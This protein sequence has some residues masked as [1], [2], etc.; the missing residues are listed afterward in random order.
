MEGLIE[1][2]SEILEADSPGPIIDAALTATAQR[3][4]SY[5]ISAYDSARA[6][7]ERLDLDDIVS[8][9]KRRLM[10]SRRPTKSSL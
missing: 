3:V 10:K 6:L 8:L 7:A 5:E 9:F 2:G 1:E 4:E